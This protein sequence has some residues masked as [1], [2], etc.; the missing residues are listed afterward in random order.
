MKITTLIAAIFVS[1]DYFTASFPIRPRV[2]Q[3]HSVK[4]PK[5]SRRVY[6]Q[7]PGTVDGITS[8]V[9]DDESESPDIP[10]WL[11]SLNKQLVSSVK[12]LL[13]YLYRDRVY[14]RFYALETIARVPY[15]SYTSVLHL[16]ETI[17]FFRRKEFIKLHFSESW[18]SC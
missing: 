8:L 16:Y 1:C 3:M 7:S 5:V 12:D 18:V 17:G 6:C 14:A 2:I 11:K 9:T 10:P 4:T 15:F 13:V